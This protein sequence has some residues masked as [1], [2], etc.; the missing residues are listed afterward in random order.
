MS[1]SGGSK[2]QMGAK[3]VPRGVPRG[4]SAFFSFISGVHQKK[5]KKGAKYHWGVLWRSQRPL[6]RVFENQR[7]PRRWSPARITAFLLCPVTTSMGGKRVQKQ[8][9]NLRSFLKNSFQIR[10]RPRVPR[11]WTPARMTAYL[12]CPVRRRESLHNYSVG[13]QTSTD[14]VVNMQSP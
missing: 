12:L 1:E 6:E 10:G 9:C 8:A 2:G 11:R 5:Q 14:P 4:C 7:V 13:G 3:E